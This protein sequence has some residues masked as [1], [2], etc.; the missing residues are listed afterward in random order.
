[1]NIRTIGCAN[2][3]WKDICGGNDPCNN[4]IHI[5]DRKISEE[6]AYLMDLHARGVESMRTAEEQ[7]YWD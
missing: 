1:M 7:E 5:D 4:Y 3:A 6:D 2:C